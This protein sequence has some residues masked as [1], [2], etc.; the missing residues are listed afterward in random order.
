MRLAEA[1]LARRLRHAAETMDGSELIDHQGGRD[2]SACEQC[3]AHCL[4]IGEAVDGLCA[5]CAEHK[6]WW[7]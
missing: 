4:P 6:G 2:C 5:R 3:A 1:E 7:G